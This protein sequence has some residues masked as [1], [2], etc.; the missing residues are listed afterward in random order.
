MCQYLFFFQGN[1]TFYATFEE[2]GRRRILKWE[3]YSS[4]A[5]L[6]R[7]HVFERGRRQ[8]QICFC[9]QNNLWCNFTC[10]L[11]SPCLSMSST[12]QRSLK[13]LC[14]HPVPDNAAWDDFSTHATAQVC[15]YLEIVHKITALKSI[16]ACPPLCQFPSWNIIPVWAVAHFLYLI[17][18]PFLHRILTCSAHPQ[19][20]GVSDSGLLHW[21]SLS[22]AEFS[23]VHID[24]I[25]TAVMS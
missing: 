20:Q 13:L 21:L 19:A 3:A 8:A 22:T 23:L 25:L 10:S 11:T 2:W 1:T 17:I 4:N 24:V 14:T 12:E 5:A 7:H 15:I 6:M 18:L 9:C 16:I